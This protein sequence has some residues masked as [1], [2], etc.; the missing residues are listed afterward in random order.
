MS[1]RVRKVPLGE[2]I[3]TYPIDVLMSLN[4][5]RLSIDWDDYNYH[6]IIGSGIVNA[7]FIGINRLSYNPTN[8]TSM[9]QI[10]NYN[11]Y[12]NRVLSSPL[13]LWN[14][15]NSNNGY[16]QFNHQKSDMW[17][18]VNQALILVI[19]ALSLANTLH[20]LF[21]SYRTYSLL[22]TDNKPKTPSAKLLTVLKM[23]G[24]SD[25]DLTILS[26]LGINFNNVLDYIT[27]N[28][29]KSLQE[30]SY[31]NDTETTNHSDTIEKEYNLFDKDI[32]Q[33]IVW[34][35]SKFQLT[36]FSFLNPLVLVVDQLLVSTTAAWKL[37]AINL[38]VNYQLYFL[39]NK[40][41]VLLQDK[42]VIY[43]EM[44]QEFNNKFVKPKTNILKRDVGIDTRDFNNEIIE[45]TNPFF[46]NTKPKVFITHDLD[47]K[48]FNT[49]NINNDNGTDLEDIEN[50]DYRTRRKLHSD[51]IR[52]QVEID[53]LNNHQLFLNNSVLDNSGGSDWMNSTVNGNSTPYKRPPTTYSRET[54]N[55]FD[56][57]Y[58]S[59]ARSPDRSS[60]FRSPHR[61]PE[62]SYRSLN[63]SPERSPN[64]FNRSPIRTSNVNILTTPSKSFVSNGS[65]SRSAYNFSPSR[66]SPSRS[67]Q[68]SP[69]RVDVDA[70]IDRL[71]P[72]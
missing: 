21:F 50:L 59:L 9:F 52:K 63:R 55:K 69:R 24:N 56:R 7:L 72:G 35:P 51:R 11:D 15:D 54:P 40:F 33:L 2:K 38:L 31:Y 64:R 13:A 26:A 65:P 12:K 14:N 49:G 27:P 61:S 22:Y 6:A 10:L 4:E 68:R 43:Q 41:F 5:I 34:D 44:F 47:G 37:L 45:Q 3:R 60:T 53:S 39:V 28:F 70:T 23:D 18:N 30:E 1:R 19:Y 32:Y 57:S 8:K 17:N 25:D 67:P 46:Q 29:F 66:A 42:Q 48:P 20:L 36:L 16:R 71:Y 62:R 58:R